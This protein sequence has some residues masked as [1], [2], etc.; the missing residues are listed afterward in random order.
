[1]NNVSHSSRRRNRRKHLA[2]GGTFFAVYDSCVSFNKPS[3]DFAFIEER[4]CMGGSYERV[5]KDE[6]YFPSLREAKMYVK[7]HF[8]SGAEY[9]SVNQSVDPDNILHTFIDKITY[10]FT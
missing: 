4:P 6:V 8:Q 5:S 7:R 10:L 2:H 3:R 9:L 1:M